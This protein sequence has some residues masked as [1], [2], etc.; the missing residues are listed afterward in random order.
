MEGRERGRKQ[1]RRREGLRER[2]RGGEIQ[3]STDGRVEKVASPLQHH[4]CSPK[5]ISEQGKEEKG[6]G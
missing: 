5:T 1:G 2:E 6:A 3:D 4:A